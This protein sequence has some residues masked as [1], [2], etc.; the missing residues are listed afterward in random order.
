[1]KCVNPFSAINT[2]PKWLATCQELDVLRFHDVARGDRV[3]TGRGGGRV[4][5]GGDLPSMLYS[6]LSVSMLLCAGDGPL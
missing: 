1:M 5:L 6:M 2:V 4:R 3:S